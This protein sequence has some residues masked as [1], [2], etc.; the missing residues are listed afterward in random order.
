M[1]RLSI[2]IVTFNAQVDALACV[3]SVHAHPPARP[4]DMVV[5]D[6]QLHHDVQPLSL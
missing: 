6:N 5:V 3:A 2:V 4:W 1:P